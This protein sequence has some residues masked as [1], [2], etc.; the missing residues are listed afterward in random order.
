MYGRK[1]NACVYQFFHFDITVLS[2][3]KNM[4]EF[5]TSFS[6]VDEIL[7]VIAYK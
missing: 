1:W 5:C 4:Q 2:T 6:T 7:S 3:I